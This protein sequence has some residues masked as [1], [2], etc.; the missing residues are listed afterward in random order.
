MST[1][2]RPFAMRKFMISQ[3]ARGGEGIAA[4]IADKRS[5]AGVNCIDM[6]LKTAS[7]NE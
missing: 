4:F 2:F 6:L 7:N 5:F 1:L 3:V